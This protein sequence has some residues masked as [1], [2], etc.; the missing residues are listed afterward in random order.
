MRRFE[1]IGQQLSTHSVTLSQRTPSARET[2][3][4]PRTAM[5]SHLPSCLVG[6][7]NG[8]TFTLVHA[9]CI[10][11]CYLPASYIHWPINRKGQIIPLTAEQPWVDRI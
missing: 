2:E 3:T 8:T 10:P 11:V 9:F 5:T 1:S 7:H 6:A 4:A